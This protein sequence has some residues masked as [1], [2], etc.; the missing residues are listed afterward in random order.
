MAHHI[1]LNQFGHISRILN[2]AGL[3]RRHGNR[4]FGSQSGIVQQQRDIRF[5]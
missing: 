2:E 3:C 1:D 5:Q 4:Y